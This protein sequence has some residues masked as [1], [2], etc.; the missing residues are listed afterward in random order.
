MIGGEFVGINVLVVE[1]TTSSVRR[2]RSC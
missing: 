1:V 2:S